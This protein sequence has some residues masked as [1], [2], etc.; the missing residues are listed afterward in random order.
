[1]A[2]CLLTQCELRRRYT[3]GRAAEKQI[4][5]LGLVFYRQVTTTWLPKTK[6]PE[7]KEAYTRG[8]GEIEVAGERRRWGVLREGRIFAARRIDGIGRAADGICGER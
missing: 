8:A 7:R 1:M 6:R 4:I 3:F 5:Y 2:V